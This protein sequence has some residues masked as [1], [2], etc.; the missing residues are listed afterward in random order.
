MIEKKDNKGGFVEEWDVHDLVW[1]KGNYKNGE[2][3]GPCE[4]FDTIDELISKGNY[5][6]GKK[7][8]LWKLFDDELGGLVVKGNYKNNQLH[9]IYEEYVSGLLYRRDE[10]VMGEEEGSFEVY[11]PGTTELQIKGK[12][13]DGIVTTEIDNT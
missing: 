6:N 13:E 11:L 2:R 7:D 3:D 10:Y 9:G 4:E 12:T 5:K 1:F 8:G